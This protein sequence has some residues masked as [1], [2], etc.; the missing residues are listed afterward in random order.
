MHDLD[1]VVHVTDVFAHFE[2]AA[3]SGSIGLKWFAQFNAALKT[4][5]K[6]GRVSNFWGAVHTAGLFHIK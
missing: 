1:D 5:Q 4:P 2:Y 6:L 3:T